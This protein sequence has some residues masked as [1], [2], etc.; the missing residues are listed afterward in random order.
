MIG[1]H[2]FKAKE[3]AASF[4]LSETFDFVDVVFVPS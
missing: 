2:F 3:L 1:I 4:S